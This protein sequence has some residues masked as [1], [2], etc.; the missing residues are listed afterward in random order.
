MVEP[1]RAGAG[2]TAVASDPAKARARRV[3]FMGVKMGLMR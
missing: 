3:L 1:A 2:I